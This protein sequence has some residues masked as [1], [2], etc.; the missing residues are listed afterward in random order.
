MN[1]QQRNSISEEI[2]E[3]SVNR[4]LKRL[5]EALAAAERELLRLG[6]TDNDAT[7]GPNPTM[8]QVRKALAAEGW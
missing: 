2:V 3:L 4:R 8:Q 7:M 1:A 6:A 5:T